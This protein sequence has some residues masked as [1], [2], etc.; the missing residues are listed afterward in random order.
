MD[1]Q[2]TQKIEIVPIDELYFDPLNPRFASIEFNKEDERQVIELMINEENLDDLAISIA[3]QGFFQG[4][5]LLVYRES[6]RLIVAEGNR[7]LAALK[8]LK[9]P[10]ELTNRQSFYD[11]ANN[12]SHHTNE[13]PCL[14]FDKREDT[15]TYLGYK[16]ITGNKKWGALEKAIYLNQLREFILDQ[17]PNL[18]VEE[19][20]RQLAR[21]VGSKAPAVGKTLAAYEIYLRGNNYNKEK[22][23]FDLQGVDQSQIEFSLIYT[24]LGYENIYTYLGLEGSTDTALENFNK[25][26]ARNLFS[27]LYK[28]DEFGQTAIPE[29]RRL[30]D[31]NKILGNADATNYFEKNRDLDSAYRLSAGPFEAFDG[32]IQMIGRNTDQLQKLFSQIRGD[33]SDGKAIDG[34]NGSHVELL[35]DLGRALRNLSDDVSEHIRRR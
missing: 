19:Q 10:H 24:A 5:P 23:F 35:S 18:S 28:Q 22:I 32:L 7:R 31:L 14:I 2:N 27:W 33:I 17:Q 26:H 29:S 30:K 8:V 4:E 21:T 20:H 11:I 34:F 6:T 16:H 12:A 15:L 3:D 25:E 13:V 1:K 9:Y